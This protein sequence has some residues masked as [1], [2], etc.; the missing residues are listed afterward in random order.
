M[1]LYHLLVGVSLVSGVSVAY[2]DARDAG[3]GF[4]VVVVALLCGL[5]AGVLS[6][7]LFNRLGDLLLAR[8]P[9]RPDRATTFR[10]ELPFIVLYVVL[11]PGIMA[12]IIF[13]SWFVRQAVHHV[14]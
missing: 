14:A 13:A 4:V 10:E 6:L 1:T 5:G 8:S 9:L 11:V 3:D 12:S 7:A 2:R